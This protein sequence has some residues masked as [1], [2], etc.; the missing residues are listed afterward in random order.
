M[1]IAMVGDLHGNLPATQ[2]L[3]DDLR[4]RGIERIFCLG[5]MVGKGPSS[6]E[7]LDWALARCEVILQGNWDSGIG[8][9]EFPADEFYYRQ[10]G[11][12]RMQILRDLPAEHTCTLS[13]RKTR[14]LHG[15]PILPGAIQT[16]GD[17]DMLET[18]FLP[19]YQAVGYA[20]VH[21]QG[22][23]V[24]KH[25]GLLFNTGSVGNA[26]GVNMVQYAIVECGS[27]TTDPLDIT[28]VTLP[29]DNER[30]AEDARKA[31]TQG[32]VNADLYIREV[33]TGYYSR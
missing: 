24:L 19:D 11:E 5:D 22:L 31:G 25:K 1:K 30:A 32:L 14:L 27:K 12:K 28:M 26:M 9:K 15:R 33:L 4:R 6:P 3:D 10:L 23:R 8:F 29:Y 7:T 20:D 21:R 13:G 2:A 17:G 18:L 16:Y